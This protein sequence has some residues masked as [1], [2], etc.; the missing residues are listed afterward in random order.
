VTFTPASTRQRTTPT[1]DTA[2]DI[3]TDLEN[4]ECVVVACYT[5][6]LGFVWRIQLIV[7]GMVVKLWPSD[8]MNVFRV[9]VGK[10]TFSVYVKKTLS[11]WLLTF[12]A[13]FLQKNC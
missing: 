8:N 6:Y 5:P 12:M 1:F 13:I 10:T 3:T 11:I 4:D 9:S 7:V 2:T